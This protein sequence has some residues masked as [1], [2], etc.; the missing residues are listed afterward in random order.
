ME[1]AI[2]DLVLEAVAEEISPDVIIFDELQ[3]LTED[4]EECIAVAFE[5]GLEVN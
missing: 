2:E 4:I 3:P 5:E 1:Q